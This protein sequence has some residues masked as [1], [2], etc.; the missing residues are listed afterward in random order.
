MANIPLRPLGANFFGVFHTPPGGS[1]DNMYSSFNFANNFKNQIDAAKAMG[2]NFMVYFGSVNITGTIANYLGQRRQ[3]VEYLASK[4]MYALTYAS[5]NLSVGAPVSTATAESVIVADAAVMGQYA[6]V[7][8]YVTEDEP[9]A[10]C[11]SEGGTIPDATIVSALASQYAAVKAVVPPDLGV[12]CAPNPCGNA[13]L[14]VFTYVAGASKTKMDSVAAYCDFLAFHPF[15]AATAAQSSAV[16]TAY[17]G[18]QILMPSSVLSNEGDADIASKSASI[19]G[20][21]GSN[22]FRGYGWFLVRDYN[23]NTWGIFAADASTPAVLTARTTKYNAFQTNNLAVDLTRHGVYR[24][25]PRL[26]ELQRW[27]Y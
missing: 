25:K 15:A 21:I 16:R 27:G 4:G 11:V 20:L 2:A 22:G 26:S 19:S 6:N 3:I 9:W 12:C 24:G 18:K 8:G 5:A 17:P 1:F 23:A 13:A 10:V 14:P 7:V